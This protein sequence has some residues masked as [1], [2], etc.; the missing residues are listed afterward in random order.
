MMRMARV[1]RSDKIGDFVYFGIPCFRLSCVPSQTD[2][3]I[4]HFCSSDRVEQHLMN[5]VSCML[6]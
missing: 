2:K 6:T 5:V 1:M 4:C 3:E